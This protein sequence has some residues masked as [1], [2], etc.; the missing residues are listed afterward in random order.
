MSKLQISNLK[1]QSSPIGHWSLFI[2]HC[3][4]FIL[5]LPALQPLLTADLTCGYDNSFHLWRA[6]QV[7]HLLRQGVLFSRWSPDM[8]HGFGYPLFDFTAP[9]SAYSVALLHL[10]GLSWPWALNL[11][12]ALGWALSAYTMYLFVR[13]LFGRHAGLVAAVLY[14]YAPFHAYDVFSRGG[15]S[16]SSAWLFPPLILWALRR[17]DRRVGFAMAALGFAGLILTHN[18]F[19]LLFAPLLLAYLFVVGYQKGRGGRAVQF[20]SGRM[21]R[22]SRTAGEQAVLDRKAGQHRLFQAGAPSAWRELN[23]PGRGVALWGGLALLVGLGLSAF[24]WLPALADLRF[25][26]SERLSGAWVFEYANN[27]LPLE[28]LLALPRNA[29]PS[30]INDS[31]ARGLG[32][33]PALLAVVGLFS[34]RDRRRRLQVAFFA[35]S[36]ALCLFLTLPVSRSVWDHLP[37]LQRVQFPWRLVGPATLCAAVLAGAALC[38]SRTTH[39]VSRFTPLLIVGAL[40]LGALGWFYPRHCSPPQD[41]SISGMI[42]WERATHTLGT[43]AKGEY[44]PVWVHRMPAGNLPVLDGAYAAGVSTS[45]VRLPPES[46]PEGARVFSADYGPL[47]ATVELESPVPFRARYLA[48]Y[49]PGWRVTVDGDPVPIAPTDPE[50]LVSFDVPAGR[51]TIRVRFGETPLRLAADVLSLLSL[52]LLVILTIRNPKSEARPLSLSPC[53]SV[54]LSPCPPV[55]LS[56]LLIAV[57][58]LVFKL[59]VVD[60]LETPLRRANLVDGRL[61]SVD[62]PTEITFG[63]EFVLL[64]YDGLPSQGVSS[65]ERFEIETY[66]RALQPG[67]PDYG[68]TVNVVGAQGHS[69]NG[70]DVRPPRWHRSPPPEWEWPL[71]QYGIVAL[72]VPLL[73]GTSPGTYT[74]ELVA[75]DQETLAPLTAHDAG[76]RALGPTLSLGQ[77]VVVAPRRPTDPD[78]LNIHHRLDAPLGPLTLLGADLDRDQAAPGDSVLLTTFWR[79]EEQPA[80]DLTVHLALLAPDGSSASEFDLPLTAPWHPTSSWQPGDVWRGQHLLHLPAHLDTATY[81]WTLSLSLS[82][83]SPV[84]LSPRPSV[85]LSP[86]PPVSLSPISITAPDR[87]YTPPPLDVETDT[88]LGQVVTLLGATL[89]PETGNLEPG[90]P[91]TVTLVWRAEAEMDVS[92]LVF[93]HLLGPGGGLAAQS[94]GEPADWTRPTTGWLPGEVI[95][96][97]RVLM[98]PIGT[99]PGECELSAGLYTLESGRLTTSRG[100]DSVLLTTIILDESQ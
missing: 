73:P 97:E 3:S 42:A 17:A 82:P 41:I 60:R 62:V 78:A 54:P 75:F 6:V 88:Q 61:R 25:V 76:G 7:E 30:L 68:V 94:D 16:Q 10:L 26:H 91:L 90:T 96:D 40:V 89:Q 12:F 45:I 95:L 52:A 23:N 79:A 29:D 15:L 53:P 84:S 5:L 4:L 92:Y 46:L 11:T 67:G 33:I 48:F 86:R 64:G 83:R 98:I 93:L 14:T 19:A 39:H 8:A 70:T 66:W 47:D 24:F 58:L 28:Q 80:D 44:L 31:P 77:I 65:G 74:V 22:L 34:L 18:A 9:A 81:T 21:S 38:P 72:S 85:S 63:D 87:T 2:D 43:T 99:E 32:L 20:S 56:L 13:D 69:W 71:D 27:F 59:A 50:G 37:L 1:S 36:L 51:H 35:A 100:T 55:S 49:Y 57:F